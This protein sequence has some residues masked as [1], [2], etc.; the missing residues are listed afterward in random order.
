LKEEYHNSE[1]GLDLSHPDDLDIDS[2]GNVYVVEG[3]SNRIQIFAP[4]KN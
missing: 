4:V 3:Y 2:S 1:E